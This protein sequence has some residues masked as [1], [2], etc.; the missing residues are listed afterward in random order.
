MKSQKT[1]NEEPVLKTSSDAIKQRT[2]N[3]PTATSRIIAN[4]YPFFEVK[5][6]FREH[7]VPESM[8]HVVY[9]DR[10]EPPPLGNS[11]K[12]DFN[13]LVHLELED[14]DESI[15]EIEETYG[16]RE[17]D[18]QNDSN[19]FK[20]ETIEIRGLCRLWLK[21]EPDG[22]RFSMEINKC[23]LEGM[24]CLKVF[25]RWSRHPDLDKYEAVLE[26]WDDRVCAEWE[27]PDQMFLNCDDWL[28]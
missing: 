18:V 21:A 12:Q 6:V 8:K 26:D 11:E 7:P 24:E 1:F 9:I 22:D 28:G 20:V 2:D 27:P 10:Y 4:D 3:K 17:E 25:K 23:L 16:M 15:E 19:V 13:P 5:G 14:E